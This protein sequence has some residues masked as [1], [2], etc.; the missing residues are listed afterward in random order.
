MAKLLSLIIWL[1]CLAAGAAEIVD[2]RKIW[3]AAPHNAFTDLIRFKEHWF[4][5]FRE[6]KG[7]VSPDGAIRVLTSLDG[8][9]WASA[10]RL[11]ST[12]ADL[13]DPKITI[14]PAN[15]LMLT[16]AGALHRPSR[17][18][19]QSYVWF[20]A[21]GT[22]WSTAAAIGDPDMWLWRVTWHRGTAYSV[23]YDTKGEQFVRLYGS[24]N[25]RSFSALV[26]KLFDEGYPNESSIIFQPDDTA[27]CL[28]RRDGAQASGKLGMAKEPYTNWDWKDV[29][30]KIGGPHMVRLRDGRIV[31]CVRLYEGG[32]RTALGWLDPKTGKLTEFQKLPSGGD[33]SYAGL[34]W[35]DPLLWVSYY[36]SHEGKTSIYLGKVKL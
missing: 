33:N 6:G 14:T 3:D 29:G 27:L 36:S 21:D 5:V 18:N 24:T 31:A 34:V 2:L 19:H 4:C 13:R 9:N 17:H 1:A 28:L 30:M 35:H 20:S 25:G 23:G 16:G 32:A 22:N 11:T 15:Q 8:T 26:P 7:H 12:N 10:A